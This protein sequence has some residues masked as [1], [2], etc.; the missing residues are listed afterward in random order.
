[1]DVKIPDRGHIRW[2]TMTPRTLRLHRIRVPIPARKWIATLG[3]ARD[4]PSS[5]SGT[6]AYAAV[7]FASGANQVVRD[8]ANAYRRPKPNWN[9]P[10]AI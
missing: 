1:L 2:E 3:T 7:T 8:R 10:P 4:A 5:P 6:R 9:D